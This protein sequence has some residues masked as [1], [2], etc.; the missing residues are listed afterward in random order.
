MNFLF[1]STFFFVPFSIRIRYGLY[2][3]L[4]ALFPTPV[5]SAL[6][7]ADHNHGVF[8]S[9]TFIQAIIKHANAITW[10]E[11]LKFI[12]ILVCA[13]FN[14]NYVI[15]ATYGYNNKK[16]SFSKHHDFFCICNA[17]FFKLMWTS[18]VFFSSLKNPICSKWHNKIICNSTEVWNWCTFDRVNIWLKVKL[19]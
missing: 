12:W 8:Y 18:L 15:I 1:V 5:R 7:I 10:S 6:R 11:H 3:F 4:S 19:M 9:K 17:C 14:E 16:T 13:T 2:A